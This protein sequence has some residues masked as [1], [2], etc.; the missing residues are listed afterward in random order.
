RYVKLYNQHIPQRAL[1]HSTPVECLKQWRRE[2]PELF[3]KRLYN[4]T[5][6]DSISADRD[7]IRWPTTNITS[8]GGTRPNINSYCG[9]SM[10]RAS[11]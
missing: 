3:R 8:L 1:K 10:G 4:Q 6:L 11:K 5:G 2:R 7:C 9:L